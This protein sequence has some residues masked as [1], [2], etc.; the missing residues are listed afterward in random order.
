M[1]SSL[2]P[3][4]RHLTR[5][6]RSNGHL[7]RLDRAGK[8]TGCS[9]LCRCQINPRHRTDARVPR[10][11]PLLHANRSPLKP[12]VEQETQG[13]PVATFG[14]SRDFPAFYT[15]KSGYPAP[16]NFTT[17]AECASMIRTS[18]RKPRKRAKHDLCS[19]QNSIRR[20]RLHPGPYSASRYLHLNTPKAKASKRRSSR[21]YG[22]PKSKGSAGEARKS[23]RGCWRGSRS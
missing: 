20:S 19:F 13:V 16:M 18:I 22:S 21:R 9:D 17:A 15:P 7:I 3:V 10:R 14:E 6:E 8:D 23:R 11:W 2:S 4:A 5:S 1:F 12:R